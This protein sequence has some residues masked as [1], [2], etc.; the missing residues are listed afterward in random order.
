MVDTQSG[1]ASTNRSLRLKYVVILLPLILFACLSLVVWRLKSVGDGWQGSPAI[2]REKVSQEA[3][4]GDSVVTGATDQPSK[5]EDVP[6]ASTESSR[7]DSDDASAISRPPLQLIADSERDYSTN[8]GQHGWSYGFYDGDGDV[9]YNCADF[10]QFTKVT[11]SRFGG[12]ELWSMDDNCWEKKGGSYFG[13]LNRTD[14]HTHKAGAIE[15]WPTRRWTSCITGRILISVKVH[16]QPWCKQGD[17]IDAHIFVDGELLWS[18]HIEAADHVGVERS[19]QTQVKPGSV[20]DFSLTP[21]STST[22][23]TAYFTARIFL[24][25]KAIELKHLRTFKEHRTK[26]LTVAFVAEKSRLLS[27]DAEGAFCLRDLETEETVTGS[28][29]HALLAAELNPDGSILACG[30]PDGKLEL[31]NVG[32]KGPRCTLGGHDDDIESVAFG[33]DGTILASG[34][35]DKTV[36]LW[37]VGSGELRHALRGHT[38]WVMALG[39]NPSGTLLAT[40]GTDQT[41][42]I[43]DVATGELLHKLEGH[44]GCVHS[45]TFNAD[46]SVLA[47]GSGAEVHLWDAGTGTLERTLLGPGPIVAF[48]PDGSTLVSANWWEKT[49]RIWDVN[50]GVLLGSRSTPGVHALAFTSD[51]S[52]LACGNTDGTVDLWRIPS[53]TRDY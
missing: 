22:E 51:R 32:D 31:W 11:V 6:I 33:P 40:G 36:M 30:G 1:A 29:G 21:C 44:G 47:A 15:H 38:D 2:S 18:Q 23:D 19:I 24:P 49:L 50:T 5:E 7:T 10:E 37:E 34:S 8:Q 27:V 16:M 4:C 52:T 39:F 17:G 26:V 13:Y 42:R 14:G 28:T 45:V 20:V 25:V 46:G 12:N 53:S 43:W 3:P 9:P 48:S 35:K 41:V